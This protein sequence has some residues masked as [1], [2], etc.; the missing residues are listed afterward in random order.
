M[1]L[2]TDS[3]THELRERGSME[4]VDYWYVEAENE[5]I[6]RVPMAMQQQVATDGQSTATGTFFPTCLACRDLHMTT[7]LHVDFKYLSVCTS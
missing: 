4:A 5:N 7:A 2:H 6:E 1:G 3:L